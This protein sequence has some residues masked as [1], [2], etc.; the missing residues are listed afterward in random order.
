MPPSVITYWAFRFMAGVGTLMVAVGLYA[1]FLIYR[2]KLDKPD[3]LLKLLP[4]VLFLPY[5]ANTSGWLLTEV[6]RYPWVVFGLVKLDA[7][8]SPTVTPGMLW[9]SLIGYMLVYGLLIVATI[10]LLK[11]YALAGPA[12]TDGPDHAAEPLPSVVGV[13]K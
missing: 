13:Q 2:H 12:A 11:K 6:G 1:L 9:V 4:W 10:Y 7:G 3:R 5:I 8:V